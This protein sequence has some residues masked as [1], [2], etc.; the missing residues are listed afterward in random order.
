MPALYDQHPQLA[1]QVP[2][3]SA[4][5]PPQL[6]SFFRVGGLEGLVSNRAEQRARLLADGAAGDEH[7]LAVRGV[8]HHLAAV[9]SIPG[10]AAEQVR[11]P[12]DAATALAPTAEQLLNATEVRLGDDGW[13]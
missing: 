11:R 9:P 7:L 5:L 1:D 12:T 3:T 6:R 13:K 10:Q 2:D 8:Q 4:D